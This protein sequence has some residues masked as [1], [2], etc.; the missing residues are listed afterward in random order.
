MLTCSWIEHLPDVASKLG[1]GSIDSL[2][3]ED[4][5]IEVSDISIIDSTVT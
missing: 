1:Y 5:V 4:M 2:S 3:L